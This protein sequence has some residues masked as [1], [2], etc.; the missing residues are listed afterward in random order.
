MLASCDSTADLT[1]AALKMIYRTFGLRHFN[2]LPGSNELPTVTSMLPL[3]DAIYWLT[4]ATWF[5]AVLFKAIAPPVVFR[6]IRQA[7]P[8]LPRV[9]SVNL[10]HQHSTLLAGDVVCD[11]VRTLARIESA[12]AFIFLPSLLAKWFTIDLSNDRLFVPVLVSALYLVAGCFHL[13]GLRSVWPRVIMHRDRYIEHADEPDVA[14]AELD[15]FDRYSIEAYNV[16]R[17]LLFILIGM[18]LLSSALVA[19]LSLT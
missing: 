10:N 1:S 15:L 13:Y 18:I 5:G 12:C 7:D 4:L 16:T 11:L 2:G 17:N 19:R 14:N 8:T 6:S 3:I 9:L